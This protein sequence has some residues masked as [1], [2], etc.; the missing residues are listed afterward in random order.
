MR[1]MKRP[2][3]DFALKMQ[4]DVFAGHYGSSTIVPS[5][6]NETSITAEHQSMIKVPKKVKVCSV[7]Q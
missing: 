1:G 6:A 3:Q 2:L 4:G 5:Q 7:D